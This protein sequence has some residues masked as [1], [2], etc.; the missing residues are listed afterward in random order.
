ML[1]Q[2]KIDALLSIP[3]GLVSP[4]PIAFPPAGQAIQLAAKS[5]DG[6]E[7]FVID[8][9]RRGKIKLTR[10]TYQERYATVEIL[11]RLDIDGPPHTNPDG[12]T[13]PCPHLHV[14]REGE[15]DKWARPLPSDFTDT[16]DLVTTLQQFLAYC[17]IAPIPVIQRSIN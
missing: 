12:Q 10:C 6:R 17:G 7:D 14:Y 1:A 13:L 11:L 9:N 2:A 3:K 8:V 15:G 5:T 4:T 16:A